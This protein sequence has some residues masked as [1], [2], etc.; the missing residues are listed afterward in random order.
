MGL[1][2]YKIEVPDEYYFQRY[3]NCRT[4]CPVG[5]NAGGYVA[6]IAQ[7]R[8]EEAYAEARRPNPFA[9]ICGR[10]CAHPCESACRRKSI[11]DPVSIRA[12]KRFAASRH[13]IEAPNPSDIRAILEHP[14]VVAG[15]TGKKIAVIGAGPAGLSCAHDLALCGHAVTVFESAPV[16]G[17]MLYLGIPEYRLPRSLLLDEIKFIEDLGV[18][19]KLNTS[20]GK[21]VQFDEIVEKHDALF[22]GAGCMKARSLN[23][24]GHD[25][26]GVLKAVDFLLN[27]NLGYKVD[28]GE[29][30]LVIGGGNVA[31][32]VARS[33][34]RYGGTSVPEEE[35]HHTM[36]DVARLAVRSGA[37]E[38][39]IVS[40]EN[41]QEMPADP[42]EIEEGLH[43]GVQII[44]SRGPKRIVGKNGR[45]FQL[46][47][48]DV[49]SV[50][51]EKGRFAP[52]FVENTEKLIAADTIIMAVGQQPDFSFLGEGHRLDF[53]DRGLLQLDKETCA[54]SNEGIFAGGDIAFGPRI[55]IEAVHD[56]RR[57]AQSINK[58]LGFEVL[59]DKSIEI[60]SF[61]THRFQLG[62]DSH[63]DIENISR[64]EPPLQSIDRRIGVT[65][66]ECTYEE[67]YACLEGARCL[68]CWIAPVFD[69]NRCI[70][71]GGCI[72]VCPELCLK[73]VDISKLE[74]T[75]ELTILLRARFG[76]KYDAAG[77][78]IKD[79]EACLRCGLCAK[80]CPTD[81]I[82]M[83]SFTCQGDL[84]ND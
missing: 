46:E 9:S 75:D 48:L 25:L 80:R 69:S 49:A 78:I 11:D 55:A 62:G 56:G 52:T 20:V 73:L 6:L 45:A 32:D 33:V 13:G 40:L 51:D 79:E 59:A 60:R 36:M 42:E 18:E 66:V 81:A 74:L 30:V 57:A 5:T 58:Y 50:F 76:E 41:E 21:D 53:T 47:T 16:P 27:F 2:K 26:D 15:T 24:E 67:K 14:G 28:V 37:R 1:A 65:E 44:N 34:A 39:T 83:Q 61:N 4:A 8:F 29:R 12:L 70:Q 7:G 84:I 31:F 38:V 71:C 77:A 63:R 54:T 17:G 72:D 35:D 22:I 82:T 10:I 43:E 19:I 23:I 68:H 64:N 3:V